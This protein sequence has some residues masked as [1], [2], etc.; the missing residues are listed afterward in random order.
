MKD[1]LARETAGLL[2]LQSQSQSALNLVT[3]TVN[4]LAEANKKIEESK[5]R[6]AEYQECLNAQN[7]ALDDLEQKNARIIENFKRLIEG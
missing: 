6:I 2:S 5:A 7:S 4:Q 1:F 3:R